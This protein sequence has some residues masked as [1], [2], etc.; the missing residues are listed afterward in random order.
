VTIRF[1]EE[2]QREFLDAIS[3]SGDARMHSERLL[4]SEFKSSSLS[5]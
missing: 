5:S 1:I 4:P 3:G 2:A